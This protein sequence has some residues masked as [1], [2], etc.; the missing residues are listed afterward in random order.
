MDV[1]YR[2]L[3]RINRLLGNDSLNTFPREPTRVTI[4]YL[5]LGNGPVNTP[6]TIWNNRRRCLPW[7]PTRGCIT[8]SSKEAVSGCQKLREFIW[9]VKKWVELWRWY[10][11][12]IEKKWQE[13]IRL[14]QE[15]FM[16]DLKLQWDGYKSVARIRLMK[17]E[18][19][20]SCVTVNWKVYRIAI[21]LYCL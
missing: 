6:K 16:Y 8:K 20:S 11:K 12:V 18:N 19:P 14:W 3:W 21:A 1:Y 2:I 4:G 9:V 7:G 15:D 10:S 13:R 17:I 5:L